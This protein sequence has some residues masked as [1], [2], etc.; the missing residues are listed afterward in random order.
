MGQA[1]NIHHSTSIL[2]YFITQHPHKTTKEPRHS[3]HEAESTA[4]RVWWPA[5]SWIPNRVQD[6]ISAFSSFHRL[7]GNAYTALQR[8]GIHR[9]RA[10]ENVGRGVLSPT[11]ATTAWMVVFSF[12][13]CNMKPKRKWNIRVIWTC[14]GERTSQNIV[15]PLLAYSH[16]LVP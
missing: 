4:H 12:E 15:R 9:D 13:W 3:V 2:W 11:S 10:S 8:N 7:D 1:L 14:V 16:H 5:K 6:D